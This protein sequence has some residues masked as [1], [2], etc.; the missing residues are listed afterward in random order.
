MTCLIAPY[1]YL[2]RKATFVIQMEEDYQANL[3]E[4]EEEKND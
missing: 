1:S 3:K 4:L 2:V